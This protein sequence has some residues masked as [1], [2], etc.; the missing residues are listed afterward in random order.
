MWGAPQ[1]DLGWLSFLTY[2]LGIRVFKPCVHVSVQIP[3]FY[4]DTSPTEVGI[5]PI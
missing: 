1:I 2:D 5:H 3:F 4:K